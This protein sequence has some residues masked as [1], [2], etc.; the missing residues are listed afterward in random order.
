MQSPGSSGFIDQETAGQGTLSIG[1]TGD[2]DKTHM[3]SQLYYEPKTIVADD[4]TPSMAGG[5]VFTTSANTGATAITDLDDVTAGQVIYLVGGSNTNSSTIADSGNFN[6]SAAWTA[7]LDA[8]L[9]LLVQ[10]DNDYL[11]LAR[12]SN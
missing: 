3:D 10:A 7:S 2:N 12:S 5:N 9:T 4:T 1:F 11:E 8:T 6:L